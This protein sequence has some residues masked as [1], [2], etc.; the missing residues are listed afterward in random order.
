[1]RNAVR[2]L[3]LAAFSVAAAVPVAAQGAASLNADLG[4]DIAQVESKLL[5]LARAIPADKYGWRPG[6]GVRSVA[7]LFKHV[8]ADNYLIPAAAG[9]PAPAAS[10]IKGDD[11]NTA[12]TYEKRELSRDAIISEL[13]QSFKFLKDALTA[14]SDMSKTAKLFGRDF[15]HQQVWI[16]A[17]THLHE[18]LG[19]AIAY[20]RSNG[21][22]PPWSR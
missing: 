8:A 3:S 9:T 2:F 1:M 14:T 6:D 20:A 17:T 13:D 7:E 19:Q 15:T 16:L 22:V 21:V 11:Y 18:H 5:G 4:R 10:G 12:M